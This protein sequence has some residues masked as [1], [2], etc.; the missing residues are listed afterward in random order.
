MQKKHLF[1]QT[2]VLTLFAILSQTVQAQQKPKQI[3]PSLPLAPILTPVTTPTVTNQLAPSSLANL[4]LKPVDMKLLVLSADGTEPSFEATKYFLDYLA[5][6]Y[7][8]IVLKTTPLPAL[9]DANKGF[10]QGIVLS[11]GNLALLTGTTWGSALTPAQW[12]LIDNYMT[13]YGVRTASMYSYPEPRYGLTMVSA[14]STN[15]TAPV[16]LSFTAA[17]SSIFPYLNRANTVPVTYAYMYYANPTPAAGETTTPFLTAGGYTVGATHKKVDGREFLALTMDHN[18][19]LMHSLALNYG[20]FNWVT[21]GVFLGERRIYMNPQV[22]DVFLANSLYAE[23]PTACK[24]SGFLVDPTYSFPDTCPEQRMIGSDLTAVR[25]WQAKWQQNAQFKNFKIAMAYNAYGLTADAGAP[26]KDDLSSQAT[27]LRNDFFWLSHTYDH[28]DLDCY[29]PVPNSGVCTPANYQ[30]SLDEVGLNLSSVS[31]MGLP[32]DRASMVTPGISGLRNANF[33]K[34]ASDLGVKYLVSDLSRTDWRPANP[35]TGV[36]SPYVPAILYIPRRATNIFYNTSTSNKGMDG[37]LV[38]EYNLF[39]GPN[40]LLRITG[41]NQPFFSV[42]QTYSDVINRE[43]DQLVQYM[44][45]GEMYPTMYHQANLINYGGGKTLLT[46]TLEAA[47]TKF[48]KISSLPVLSFNQ[49]DLGKKLEDRMALL[50]ANTKATYKPGI[51]VTITSSG[52]ASAPITGIC[53]GACENYG[54][55]NISK[56]SVPA[57]GTVT[58]PLF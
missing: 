6:P 46:D 33:L 11:T 16:Q 48:Q 55:T 3:A 31:R 53:S 45:R 21:K 51:G 43:S 24:P 5:I 50:S 54:G 17:A 41:T 29:N 36:R 47:F 15:P 1:R 14:V 13:A 2:I 26:K 39:Y 57:N 10:Y 25:T 7:D 58:I 9:N 34:A 40:G 28:E 23:I 32:L 37:S 8:A 49:S 42:L 44:L 52:A 20:V 18:A 4:Y 35:N 30:E 12:A 19:Y 22:D 56:I 27:A 38:D